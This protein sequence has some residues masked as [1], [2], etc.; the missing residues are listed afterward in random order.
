MIHIQDPD[1]TWYFYQPSHVLSKTE[2]MGRRSLPT[3]AEPL[4]DQIAILSSLCTERFGA[5]AFAK[6]RVVMVSGTKTQGVA[7]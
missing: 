7:L 6:L 4:T 2:G 3:S 1:N 5:M